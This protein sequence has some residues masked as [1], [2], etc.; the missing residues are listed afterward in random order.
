MY[1]YIL[2]SNFPGLLVRSSVWISRHYPS[3]KIFISSNVACVVLTVSIYFLK[4][5]N[6]EY[7]RN[8]INHLSFVFSS[9]Y[10]ICNKRAHYY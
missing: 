6:I 10:F 7:L 3:H 2:N 1:L 9:M 8:M 5:Q 4:T